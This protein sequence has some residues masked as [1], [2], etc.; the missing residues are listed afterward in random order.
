MSN[1]N[2]ISSL[3]FA[4]RKLP[5]I[6][7]SKSINHIIILYGTYLYSHNSVPI[8]KINALELFQNLHARLSDDV[9][10]CTSYNL[11]W[12]SSL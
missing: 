7:A 10:A 1:V 9:K 4:Q 3:P 11:Y 8:T 12:L 6:G 5:H 2:L